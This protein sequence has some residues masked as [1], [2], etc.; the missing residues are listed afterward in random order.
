MP[1]R[2]Y[3]HE[4]AAYK[5]DRL[6]KLGMVPV[7]V[8]RQVDGKQGSLQTWVQ[9]AVDRDQIQQY[10]AEALLEGLEDE[11]MRARVFT[12]LIGSIERAAFGEMLVP[13]E[14]RIM[15]ADNT[16]AFPLS[17]EVELPE[18]CA[19]APDLELG[20]RG[21]TKKA[22]KSAVG[23]YLSDDQIKALL[24]RRDHILENCS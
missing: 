10:D 14:R 16:K 18:G 15:L 8:L 9:A 21:L 7:T 20:M 11:I 2:R 24:G 5:L 12:R 19:I 4:V 13:K 22:L 23:D 3:V 6:M 1:A 17:S